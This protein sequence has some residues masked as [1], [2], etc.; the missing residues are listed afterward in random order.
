MHHPDLSASD[1]VLLMD[2][3]MVSNPEGFQFHLRASC[4]HICKAGGRLRDGDANAGWK[5]TDAC[6]DSICISTIAMQ[7]GA[8]ISW[9]TR[10]QAG[11]QRPVPKIFP[12]RYC[13]SDGPKLPATW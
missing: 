7:G 5:L 8:S 13:F 4:I 11:I 10:D 2:R 9:S 6:D 12:M 3:V 1:R